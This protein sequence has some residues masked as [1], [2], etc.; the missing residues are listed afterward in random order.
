MCTVR[1]SFSLLAPNGN[2][3][4]KKMKAVIRIKRVPKRCFIGQR[5][6]NEWDSRERI[7]AT[8]KRKEKRGSP[9]RVATRTAD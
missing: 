3:E 9:K 8:K 2:S 4:E 6:E 7:Q 5:K 1:N